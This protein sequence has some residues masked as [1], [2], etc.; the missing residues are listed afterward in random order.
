L[1]A[2]GGVINSFDL[3]K[4]KKNKFRKFKNIKTDLEIQFVDGVMV[5]KTNNLNNPAIK[6]EP[7]EITIETEKESFIPRYVLKSLIKIA[8]SLLIPE[9]VKYFKKTLDWLITP[10][11]S[12]TESDPN[13]IL[14]GND[15]RPP[16]KNP[17]ALLFRKKHECNSPEFCLL[18]MYGFHLYQIF[19]PF[20]DIDKSLDLFNINHPIESPNVIRK[21]KHTGTLTDFID[22]SPRKREKY[23]CSIKYTD[24]SSSNK[25]VGVS[26]LFKSRIV[27]KTET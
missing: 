22:G 16:L 2:F 15:I 20:C 7:E 5:I 21:I 1:A 23:I 19:L 24:M 4:N 14:Y 8:I 3:I 25:S 13:M 10:K 9:D 6:I 17:I 26:D 11:D 27:K 18:F 12:I